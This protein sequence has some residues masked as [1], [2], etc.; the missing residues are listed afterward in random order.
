ML[1]HAEAT[2]TLREVRTASN[3]VVVAFFTSDTADINESDISDLS[4]W[5]LTVSPASEFTG[6]SQKLMP[7]I[8]IS[9]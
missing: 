8:I 9:T 4:R 5:K 7:L 6:I 1:Q 2:L 3:D